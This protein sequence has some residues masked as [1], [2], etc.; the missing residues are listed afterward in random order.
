[1]NLCILYFKFALGIASGSMMTSG[2]S[3]FSVPNISRVGGYDSSNSNEFN[4]NN[5]SSMMNDSL[6]PLNAME[7]TISDQVLFFLIKKK[8]KNF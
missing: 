5:H 7:K 4:S 2:P 1:M 3:G 6:D 8:L